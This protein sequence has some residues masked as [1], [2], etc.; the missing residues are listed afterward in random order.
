MKTAQK[1]TRVLPVLLLI[2]LIVCAG[3]FLTACDSGKEEATFMFYNGETT[4]SVKIDVKDFKDKSVYDVL[5]SDKY[6]DRL[7]ADIGGTDLGHYV[8]DIYDLVKDN[9]GIGFIMFYVDNSEYYT[10][11]EDPF[12]QPE[13]I[14]GKTFYPPS[15]DG[16]AIG[17]DDMPVIKGTSYIFVLL[18]M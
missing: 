1:L 6:K 10:E 14:N 4:E 2:V 15:I 9:E 17:I 11:T 5:I 13:T 3:V 12:M 16:A 8:N 18:V 7:K